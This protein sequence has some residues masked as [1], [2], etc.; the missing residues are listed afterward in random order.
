[1]RRAGTGKARGGE[2][3]LTASDW[4]E[5]AL[6]LIAEK[7]LSALTVSTLAARLGVTK[8]SFYWHFQ[9]RAELL[10]A[11]LTRWEQ[12]ATTEAMKGLDAVAD[13]R[14]RLELM[15]EA[16]SQPPRSRSLYAA[17][18]EAAEDPVVRRTLNRV[19]TARIGY[20][21]KCYTQLGFSPAQARSHAVFAYAAYRGLL[22]LAHEAPAALPTDWS[23][24]PEVIRKALVPERARRM[25]RA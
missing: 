6:Q 20:L 2:P 23:S 11:A 18:A 17:L 10:A 21:E 7:G 15:L 19:A 1:M 9:G 24:Y 3:T 14:R 4:A 25:R 5:A 8:G 22:Q 16:A 12:G 13:D